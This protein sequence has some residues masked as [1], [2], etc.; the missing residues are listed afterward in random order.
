LSNEGSV[1]YELRHAVAWLGLNRPHKRN[2]IGEALLAEL[3]AV[4]RRAQDEARALVFSAT[5][6]VSQPAST[7]RSTARG[8]R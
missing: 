5:A 7:S 4:V 2:A 1:T 8:N 3:E 6:P